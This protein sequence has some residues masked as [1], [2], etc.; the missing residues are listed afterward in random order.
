MR[1]WFRV[2]DSDR[3]FDLM[4]AAAAWERGECCFDPPFPRTA[5]GPLLRFLWKNLESLA[6]PSFSSLHTQF[7]QRHTS[8]FVLFVEV[9]LA[10]V[11]QGAL[12]PTKHAAV[13]AALAEEEI[14]T[15]QDL[16][17]LNQQD[18]EETI[19]LIKPPKTRA[20]VRKALLPFIASSG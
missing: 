2:A 14:H 4:A 16:A 11:I 8:Q 3:A 5:L 6:V 9:T 19:K 7:S 12:P 17:D 1:V 20:S 13:L 10:S 15:L 18:L